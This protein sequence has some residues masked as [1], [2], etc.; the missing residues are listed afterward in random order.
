MLPY[1]VASSGKGKLCS[2]AF[3]IQS[4]VYSTVITHRTQL[5]DLLDRADLSTI[6]IDNHHF[7]GIQSFIYDKERRPKNDDFDVVFKDNFAHDFLCGPT[8]LSL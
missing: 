7:N 6:T 2:G 5:T 8:V 4:T 3:E 1:D